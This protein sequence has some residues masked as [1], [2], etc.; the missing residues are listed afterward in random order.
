MEA[1]L[2]KKNDDFRKDNPEEE[3][4]DTLKEEVLIPNNQLTPLPTY[5]EVAA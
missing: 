5:E 4:D 2:G 1:A 3:S